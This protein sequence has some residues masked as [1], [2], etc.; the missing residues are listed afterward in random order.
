MKKKPE[1][2]IRNN[3]EDHNLI[4]FAGGLN[5]KSSS[6]MVYK[7]PFDIESITK[8]QIQPCYI[9]ESDKYF[10]LINSG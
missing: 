6:I 10:F 1:K 3:H 5:D 7:K 4:A 2:T 8:T 9:L